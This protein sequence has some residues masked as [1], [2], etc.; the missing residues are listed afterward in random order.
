MEM[1]GCREYSSY[2]VEVGRLCH[3]E[4]LKHLNLK[5]RIRLIS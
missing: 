2:K 1:I 3:R 5:V 4:E